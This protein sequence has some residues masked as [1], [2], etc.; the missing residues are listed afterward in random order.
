MEKTVY[1]KILA[2]EEEGWVIWENE[3]FAAILTHDPFHEGHTLV[4]PKVNS[5]DDIFDL[6]D[7]VYE[8]LMKAVKVVGRLLKEKLGVKRVTIW[9]RGFQ[10]PHVHV[11]LIPAHPEVNLVST[12]RKSSPVGHRELREV[13]RKLEN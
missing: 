11:H 7:E 13:A 8:G 1:E 4:I 5:G 9:V 3:G 12:L 10:V 2:G 6:E